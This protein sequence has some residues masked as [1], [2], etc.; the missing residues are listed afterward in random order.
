MLNKKTFE[1][2]LKIACQPKIVIVFARQA[3]LIDRQYDCLK[4]NLQT[5]IVHIFCA[6]DEKMR[7]REEHSV[8]STPL[9]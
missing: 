5:Y 1:N 9:P 6:A 2:F 7:L 4:H 3:N 8:Y